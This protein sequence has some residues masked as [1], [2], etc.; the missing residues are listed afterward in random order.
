METVDKYSPATDSS[1][2]VCESTPDICWGFSACAF[3]DEVFVIGGKR[4][5]SDVLTNRC[6][7]F[8]AM[9][10]SWEEVAAMGEARMWPASAVQRGAVVICG[11]QAEENLY[12]RKT[13]ESYD[14]IGD[15]GGEWRAWCAEG[16]VTVW[17]PSTASC[18]RWAEK[19]RAKCLTATSF[20]SSKTP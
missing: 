7:R 1:V 20:P 16:A 4:E 12:D 19:I 3:I 18:L 11:G 2:T 9:G 15:S 13:V 10:A 17:W 6:W 8:D 14:V 5:R